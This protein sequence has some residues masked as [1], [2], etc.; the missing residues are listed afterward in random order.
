MTRV[1]VV[2]D[3]PDIARVLVNYLLHAG[4]EA[5]H[6]ADGREALARILA[7]PPDLTL[8][9]V[10]LPG[11]DGMQVLRQA[12]AATQSPVIMLT[13]RVEEVDRLLGLELGAD[14]YVCKPFSPREVIAR[15]KAVL[16][17]NPSTAGAPGGPAPAS[18]LVLDPTLWRASLRGQALNLTRRE[19]RLLQVLSGQ[20]GRIFSRGRLL[21]LAYDDALDVNER[22][23]D[24][25]IKNLRKKLATADPG[26]DWIRN[27]YGVGYSLEEK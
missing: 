21:E 17:R 3:D 11:L 4:Y 25:H 20:A 18:G 6:L 23:I 24:S 22:A 12:R 2:E 13:A 15:V 27:V 26:A 7:A 1:L 9:D 5:E 14:D 19:F 16:R 10:M 8:L